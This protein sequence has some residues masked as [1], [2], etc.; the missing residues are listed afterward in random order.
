MSLSTTTLTCIAGSFIITILPSC[1]PSPRIS[2]TDADSLPS[3]KSIR[4]HHSYPSSINLSHLKQYIQNSHP[5]IQA[6]NLKLVEAQGHIDQAGRHAN[7]TLTVGT[8]KSLLDP[9][10]SVGASFS[11]VFPVTNRLSIEKRISKESF[12]M[13]QQEIDIVTNAIV[14]EAQLHAVDFLSV[15]AQKSQINKQ[16]K[17]LE[18]LASFIE[19]AA[20]K[21]ELSPLDA[22]QTR[23]EI[24]NLKANL[25]ALSDQ[26]SI[27]LTA[28]KTSLG[29]PASREIKI[30]GNLN[31]SKLPTSSLSVEKLPQIRLK[32]WELA[33]AKS[34][35]LLQKANR[36]EDVEMSISG[37]LGSTKDEPEDREAEAAI[38]FELS[39]PLPL[40][41]KN[42]GNIKAATAFS[43]RIHLEKKAL[44]QQI[45]SEASTQKLMMQTW[46]TQ[47]NTL[48]TT[49]LPAARRNSNQLDKAYR[50]GQGSFTDLLKSKLQELEIESQIV[51]NTI[52]FHKAKVIYLATIGQSQQAF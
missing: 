40:Y 46:L 28:F 36:F 24:S 39:I 21:G 35:V 45:R 29:I 17:A 38:G 16:I 50:R 22:N 4:T 27:A 5:R 2:I 25:K 43:K 51:E 14:K 23:F 49:L 41:D 13:A 30:I 1:I 42:E 52:A 34:N 7:P 12:H 33:Q 47:N 6:A 20:A 15:E 44:E 19:A 31:S 18:T 11:Q 8:G 3:Y 32:H 37:E 9:D 26:K 10:L 48:R